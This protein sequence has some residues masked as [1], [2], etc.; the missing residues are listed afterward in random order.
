M[1]GLCPSTSNTQ[2]VSIPPVKS[3]PSEPSDPV[4]VS[5]MSAIPVAAYALGPAARSEPCP[6]GGGD[7]VAGVR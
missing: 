5:L 2:G 6:G 3:R 7:R 1:V 4:M